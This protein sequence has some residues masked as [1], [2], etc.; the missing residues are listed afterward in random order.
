MRYPT[1][2][3]FS[4]QDLA[5]IQIQHRNFGFGCRTVA[6]PP[7]AYSGAAQ[8]C[9]LVRYCEMRAGFKYPQPGT[10]RERLDRALARLDK[11][12][13]VLEGSISNM[14][15]QMQQRRRPDGRFVSRRA[16]AAQLF[17]ADSQLDML[18]ATWRGSSRE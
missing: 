13:P 7:W 12:R 3:G 15:V 17:N 16:L 1:E 11:L 6:T 5:S 9:L 2:A 10:E 18:T 14:L 8:R 4:F